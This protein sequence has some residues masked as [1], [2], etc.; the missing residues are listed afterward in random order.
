MCII[1]RKRSLGRLDARKTQFRR[2]PRVDGDNNATA[3]RNIFPG[4]YVYS[5]EFF[6]RGIRPVG[7]RIYTRP[8]RR[9][10]F[11]R[12]TRPNRRFR[13]NK[14]FARGRDDESLAVDSRRRD[15]NIDKC[16]KN[17]SRRESSG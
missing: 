16:K 4:I 1:T 9:V 5:F 10:Q 12:K 8:R 11:S 6:A 13:T 15:D 17:S 7:S 14:L 2:G 3:R